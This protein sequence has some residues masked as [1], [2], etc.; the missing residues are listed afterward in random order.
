MGQMH[1]N[2]FLN[3]PALLDATMRFRSRQ[4]LYFAGQITGVEGYVGNL[5]TGLIAALN[6]SRQ[7]RWLSPWIPPQDTM[8]GALCHYVTHCPVKEFQPMKANLGILPPLQSQGQRQSAASQRPC[9]TR[10]RV[11]AE[12][13]GAAGRRT[14]RR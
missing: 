6:L 9:Q 14:D 5:A 10:Q 12:C 4:N 13:A 11:D 1:R 7:L 2:T 8:I 3:A